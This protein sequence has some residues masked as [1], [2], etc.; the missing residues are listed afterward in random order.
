MDRGRSLRPAPV[1]PASMANE[2]NRLANGF[3][4]P[5]D[6]RRAKAARGER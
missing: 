5:V 2:T 3:Q 4:V 1:L 6:E